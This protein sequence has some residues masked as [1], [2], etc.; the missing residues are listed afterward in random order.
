[1]KLVG[2]LKK[3]V[4]ETNN[5]EEAKELIENAGM[6]LTDEELD[7][8]TGGNDDFAIDNGYNENYEVSVNPGDG[9]DLLRLIQKVNQNKFEFGGSKF[10][11]H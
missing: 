3:Q 7:N 5:K 4:E 6:L 11:Q 2:E 10:H 1:M 8:V 9:L